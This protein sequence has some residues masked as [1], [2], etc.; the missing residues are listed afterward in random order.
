MGEMTTQNV[1]DDEELRDLTISLLRAPSARD[2]QMR[3]GASDLSNSCDRCLG[4]RLLG[5]T[6]INPRSGA[7]WLKADIG[8]SMHGRLDRQVQN[9]INDPFFPQLRTAAAEQHLIFGHIKG[10]GDVGGSIDLHFGERG[11]GID[12]KGSD[13][14]QSALLMDALLES[15]DSRFGDE[16]RFK[17]GARGGWNFQVQSRGK[18]TAHFSDAEYAAEKKAMLH[19]YAKYRAQQ[20][21]YALGLELQ[22][23]NVRKWSIVWI[24][25][26][27][28]G[29]YDNPSNKDYTD[30]RKQRDIWVL[31]FNYDRNFALA[32]IQRAQDIW[33]RLQ[34]GGSPADEV[35]D[36]G[37]FSCSYELEQE[38]RDLDINAS[39]AA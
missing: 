17:R 11:Q 15:G 19:K 8:T 30:P 24:N 23:V 28:T 10:Y 31:S 27:G 35:Q 25:R 33:D 18:Q 4:H 14:L 32:L 3:V 9:L 26:D 34:A 2:L 6:I 16:P 12:Y 38:M 20:N 21:L 37:C 36:P 13:R 5:N 22:G 29:F 1:L 39:M 7:A